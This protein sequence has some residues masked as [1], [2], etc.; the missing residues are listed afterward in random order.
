MKRKTLKGL[1]CAAM[2]A[3]TLSVTACGSDGA[4]EEAATVEE[5]VDETAEAEAEEVEEEE[6]EAEETADEAAEDTAEIEEETEEAEEAVEETAEEAAAGEAATLEEYYSDPS[7]KAVLDAAFESLAEDGMSAAV[8][9]E[10][11]TMTVVIKLEDDTYMTDGI[12]EMLQDALE[13][14][15]SSF[16]E[17]AAEFDEIIGESGACTVV[18][19]YLD[20]EDNVLAEQSY[21]AQ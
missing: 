6:A 3:M 18:M 19:R 9:M 12:G 10:G 5:A 15:A 11:N 20:P 13:Q 1:A 21:T 7:V 16:E 8:E 4:A 14:Q 17:Q 2:L